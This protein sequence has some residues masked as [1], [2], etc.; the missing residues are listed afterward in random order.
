MIWSYKFF[1]CHR[2]TIVFF[3]CFYYFT[4]YFVNC[5]YN[6]YILNASVHFIT[7]IN[8]QFILQE[9]VKHQKKKNSI[10][11]KI[12]ILYYTETT[13]QIVRTRS[14]KYVNRADHSSHHGCWT[15]HNFYCKFLKVF[16]LFFIIQARIFMK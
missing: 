4:S 15:Y 7:S 5:T 6:I 12:E 11:N 2:I 1:V 16:F 10:L 3:I 14:K 9:N 8:I 13:L